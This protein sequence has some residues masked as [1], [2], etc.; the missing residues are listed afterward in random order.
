MIRQKK[1]NSYVAGVQL[2]RLDERNKKTKKNYVYILLSVTLFKVTTRT[3]Q[4]Q[5][6]LDS[7]F[8]PLT[9]CV[10]A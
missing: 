5:Q 6:P 1:T 2:A 8:Y 9:L 7:S 10:A 3:N 4:L